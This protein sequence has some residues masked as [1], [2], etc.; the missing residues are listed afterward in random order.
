[1]CHWQGEIHISTNRI[2]EAHEEDISFVKISSRGAGVI[3]ANPKGYAVPHRS[4]LLDVG[5]LIT[6]LGKLLLGAMIVNRNL[7]SLAVPKAGT[8]PTNLQ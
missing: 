8:P 6:T 2:S 3:I 5:A 1:M 4:L 7:R